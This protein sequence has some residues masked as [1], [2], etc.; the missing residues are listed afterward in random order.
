MWSGLIELV[1]LSVSMVAVWST[2]RGTPFLSSRPAYPAEV[3]APV[4]VV[5]GRVTP[6]NGHLLL[7]SVVSG[8][9]NVTIPVPI[10]GFQ[11]GFRPV[12]IPLNTVPVSSGA[13][14]G[15]SHY[16][17]SHSQVVHVSRSQEQVLP[18]LPDLGVSQSLHTVQLPYRPVFSEVGVQ[19]TVDTADVAAGPNVWVSTVPCNF[20]GL[21]NHSAEDCLHPYA[22]DDVIAS[23]YEGPFAAASVD[24]QSLLDRNDEAGLAQS[25]DPAYKW[26]LTREDVPPEERGLRV[27]R[28]RLFSSVTSVPDICT[29][30]R[31]AGRRAWRNHVY[32]DCWFNPVNTPCDHC[33]RI[34][35]SDS[36]P[37]LNT[38]LFTVSDQFGVIAEPSLGALTL[39]MDSIP[40][41]VFW[42]IRF[43][44]LDEEI[45]L[46]RVEGRYG[47]GLK[48]PHWVRDD[49]SLCAWMVARQRRLSAGCFIDVPDVSDCGHCEHWVGQRGFYIPF[50]DARRPVGDDRYC[51]DIR[52]IHSS[53]L[54]TAMCPIA[55]RVARWM[56]WEDC[57]MSCSS[58]SPSSADA[59]ALWNECETYF[60]ERKCVHYSLTLRRRDLL[61][62]LFQ[63]PH[64]RD[65]V[66]QLKETLTTCLR[67]AVDGPPLQGHTTP[68]YVPAVSLWSGVHFDRLYRVRVG[69]GGASLGLQAQFDAV[70]KACLMTYYK[71]GQGGLVDHQVQTSFDHHEVVLPWEF[72]ILHAD[73]LRLVH[74][75]SG[76]SRRGVSV[77]VDP[78]PVD[79]VV[80]VPVSPE[81]DVVRP[82]NLEVAQLLVREVPPHDPAVVAAVE[83]SLASHGSPGGDRAAGSGASSSG[84]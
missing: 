53:L 8:S 35:P 75:P 59:D 11:A 60:P 41:Q 65:H 57:P 51:Q 31:D 48:I 82:D 15:S 73:N 5:P 26:V 29:V 81:V 27:T 64:Q 23:D 36:C 55:W 7:R 83:H 69:P 17:V 62:Y 4:R 38:S 47:N 3:R 61:P 58:W 20:C 76:F 16:T 46:H 67:G 13:M 39:G 9:G 78:A 56:R 37:M 74:G 84:S 21:V 28:D 32:A 72:I 49:E 45:T 43:G 79:P 14:L 18:G 33:G 34:H 19:A 22:R 54:H 44:N 30:C 12:P 10:A 71:D 52:R 25:S 63:V 80:S 1:V 24:Q 70:I 77:P 42:P 40:E 6:T 68:Y 66:R 50:Y 2:L